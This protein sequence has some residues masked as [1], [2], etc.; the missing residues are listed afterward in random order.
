M[1]KIHPIPA[2]NDNYIWCIYQT[3]SATAVVV[4]PGDSKPVTQFLEQQGLELSTVLITHHHHDHVGGLAALK[5]RYSP[6]VYGPKAG[7]NP[8][9]DNE[10]GEGNSVELFGC[11]LQVISVPGHTLDHIAYYT[12]ELTDTPTLFCGDT[13]FAA[14]CGRLFEGSPGMMLQSLNKLAQLP[15][16]TKVYCAHEYTL[17]NLSFALTVEP[18]N[19]DLQ[20]RYQQAKQTRANMQP[21]LPSTIDLELRTNPF[22]RS[23]QSSVA[24]A[25]ASHV[26]RAMGS[27]TEVF[28]A[29][30]A[31]KDNF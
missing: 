28:A 18:E 19:A 31:W 25:A 14:G 11:Q 17:A 29:I 13:L 4:D 10:L 27:E 12:S 2:F 26:G 16:E 22:L 30:R 20:Q 1:I 23:D 21:T 6:T 3:D 7:S 15:R 24:T 9:F 5:D 8:L